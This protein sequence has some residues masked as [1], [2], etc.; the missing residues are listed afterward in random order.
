MKSIGG[1][2]N[3]KTR[4]A[5]SSP[6]SSSSSAAAAQKV[7]TK[8]IRNREMTAVS[9]VTRNNQCDFSAPNRVRITCGFCPRDRGDRKWTR[10]LIGSD[11]TYNSLISFWN[12]T[13]V[14]FFYLWLLRLVS[15]KHRWQESLNL[16]FGVCSCWKIR[17][18]R[19]RRDLKCHGQGLFSVYF[20]QCSRIPGK[21][22]LH[23]F[24]SKSD[25]KWSLNSTKERSF[26][27]RNITSSSR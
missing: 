12:M 6:C 27:I 18:R 9:F 1:K 14:R 15:A 11:A 7:I 24:I 25:E 8:M 5:A 19:R 16:L 2:E 10:W 26:L 3:C 23:H 22:N 21:R 17:E 4:R 20:H 13:V